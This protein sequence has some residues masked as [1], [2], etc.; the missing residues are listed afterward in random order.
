MG[1]RIYEQIDTANPQFLS[2][3]G[4]LFHLGLELCRPVHQ[5]IFQIL[6]SLPFPSHLH[7]DGPFIAAQP[8]DEFDYF[9]YGSAFPGYNGLLVSPSGQ[10]AQCR[11]IPIGIAQYNRHIISIRVRIIEDLHGLRIVLWGGDQ[12]KHA[13]YGNLFLHAI[14]CICIIGIQYQAPAV[15]LLQKFIGLPVGTCHPLIIG[16]AIP[17]L[18]GHCK[19]LVYNA[20]CLI[21]IFVKLQA[22][23]ISLTF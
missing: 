16:L 3:I 22:F 18:P 14:P 17:G 12:G 4:I 2:G 8:V 21:A 6:I 9:F 23:F 15:C 7:P 5:P 20:H 19:I 11:I 10:I 1:S 13:A